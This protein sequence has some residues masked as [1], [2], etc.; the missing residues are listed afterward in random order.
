[1]TARSIMQLR[2]A[3]PRMFCPQDWYADEPFAHLALTPL[4]GLPTH[5]RRTTLEGIK[6]P[7]YLTDAVLLVDLYLRYP[8]DAIFHRYLVCGDTDRKGQRVLVGGT[9]NGRG[10]EIHRVLTFDNMLSVP[11]WQ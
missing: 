6:C 5:L 10:I 9:E 11:V 2:D 7:E 3:Y 8:S 1:M 4:I